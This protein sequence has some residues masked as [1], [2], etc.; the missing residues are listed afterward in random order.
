MNL[1]KRV[2]YSMT[3]KTILHVAAM[4][5]P[6]NAL[7]VM[8]YRL[9]GTRIGRDVGIGT[10]TFIEESRPH[11]VTIEDGVNIGPKAI[12]VAHDSSYHC[13]RDSFPILFGK[14]L[15]K[16]KAYVGAGAIIL[17]GV[18]VGWG[19]IVAAGAVVTKD[20][21]DGAIVAGV[22]AKAI[23]TVEESLARPEYSNVSELQA[24][25]GRIPKT[26]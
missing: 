7:S 11:L 22:P 1:Y 17:P 10:G 6:H 15:I 5:S 14:V 8:F 9:R 25:M 13:I 19:S 2:R 12:I 23:S 21:D 26:P 4:N 24:S 18:T 16:S 3:L 20:V